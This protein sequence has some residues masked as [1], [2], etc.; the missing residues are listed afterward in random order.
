MPKVNLKENFGWCQIANFLAYKDL[1][2]ALVVWRFLFKKVDIFMLCSCE[3]L[4]VKE[5]G[6]F[7][8]QFRFYIAQNV[9]LARFRSYRVLFFRIKHFFGLYF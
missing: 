9:C 8:V 3:K 1:R 6:H 4:F 5:D 2:A 7:V